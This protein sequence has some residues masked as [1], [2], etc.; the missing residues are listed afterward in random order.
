MEMDEILKM[1]KLLWKYRWEN[2]LQ[3]DFM[4]GKQKKGG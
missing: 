1:V 3:K 4:S 2:S